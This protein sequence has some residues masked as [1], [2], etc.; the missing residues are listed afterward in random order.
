ML[1]EKL[2]FTLI[3]RFAADEIGQDLVEY[4]LLLAFVLV[5]TAGIFLVSG[6]SFT[7]VWTSTNNN[8]SKG[9]QAVS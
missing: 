8:L 1:R 6:A 9:V 3:K 2:M 5:I 4:E 7:S